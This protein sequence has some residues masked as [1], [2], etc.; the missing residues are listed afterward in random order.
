VTALVTGSNG[1]VGA[2]VVERLLARG[3][4]VRAFVR[5]GS[6]LTRLEALRDPKRPFE[7]FRG[8][9]ASPEA[10]AEALS[11]V[12]V[13]YHLAA[14]LRGTAADMFL[15]T[16]VTSKNLL[17][18][19]GR[20][21]D[22][23]RIVLV[24]SFSVYGV[25]KLPRG[26]V[27]DES[28]PVEDEPLARDLYALTKLR[29]ERL[30][31]EASEKYH[32]DLVVLRPGVIYGPTSGAFSARVGLQMP[33]VFLHL[34]RDN[35]LPL[36]YVDN[37]AEAIVQAGETAAAVGQIY[38]VVDDDLPTARDYL[39]RYKRE[40]APLRS[41]SVPYPLLMLGSHLVERYHVHSKGQLPAIFTPYK[42]ASNW[43]GNRFANDKLKALG[44]RPLV[45]TDEGIARTF[46]YLRARAA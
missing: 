40:V 12:R 31:W 19:A 16:V 41:L 35:L 17:E 8:S 23:P 21:K 33:G 1:F 9:L 22:P 25:A 5:P 20:M 42:T 14:A 39:A 4:N 7:I 3:Q 44:W 2:R 24:S 27:V 46:G 43:K 26:A 18:A 11:G 37:C 29:Q 28:T 10:A 34:G 13:V 32:L 45:T 36:T 30:F 6:D 38:N 15:G